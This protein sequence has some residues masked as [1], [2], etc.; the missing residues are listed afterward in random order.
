MYDAVSELLWGKF[1]N[2]N[3]HQQ[4]NLFLNKATCDT[5]VYE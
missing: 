5:T 2:I 4:Y 3:K 1:I